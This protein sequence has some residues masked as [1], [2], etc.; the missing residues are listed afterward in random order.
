MRR[1]L[2]LTAALVLIIGAAVMFGRSARVESRKVN[3]LLISIDTVRADHLGCYGYGRDTSPNIDSLARRGVLFTNATSQAP[4]TLVSHMSAFTSLL[5]SY[6]KVESIN[7]ILSPAIPVLAE[8]LRDAGWETAGI[9]NDGQM[10]AHWGFARG[11]NLWEERKAMTPDGRIALEGRAGPIT[12]RTITWVEEHVTGKDSAKPFF[13]FIHYFDAHDPYAPPPP[14]D[15]MFAP[16]DD[17]PLDGEQTGELLQVLR[18]TKE[19]LSD[20]RLLPKLISLYDGEIRYNDYHIG[21]LF[22]TLDRLGLR[23]DTLVI[24]F[25]DHG[26]EFREHGSFLHGGTLYEE[27]IRVPLIISL[28]GRV[29]EGVRAAQPARLIDI[30]PTIFRLCGVET[31]PHAQGQSLMPLEFNVA[32]FA[33]I[34]M[35]SETKALLEGTVLKTIRLCDLKYI[36]SPIGLCEELYDLRN[37]PREERNLAGETR[38][39]EEFRRE[40]ERWFNRTEHYWLIRFV[41][42]ESYTTFSATLELDKGVFGVIVPVGFILSPAQ[43]GTLDSLSFSESLDRLRVSVSSRGEIK[44]I[45]VESRPN[46]AAITVDLRIDEFFAEPESVYI[47]K[48]RRNPEDM[49]FSIASNLGDASSPFVLGGNEPLLAGPVIIIEEYV[50]PEKTA[51]PLQV[52]TERRL[53]ETILRQLRQLGYMQ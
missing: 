47:G 31:P 9:V 52:D 43:A 39:L 48:S 2:V 16:A 40:M 3:V 50:S 20:S 14:Y 27:V 8:L 18:W 19:P 37:D 26:E 44:A 6:H 10:Q 46:G 35:K 25:S 7:D 23:D 34:P 36:Y 15:T 1:R 5:P 33:D 53:D 29:P 49:P 22:D 28:P 51:D 41:P 17:I 12:D 32:R 30:L 21:R 45:Y 24:V 38:A 11:F 13:L 4:W 42:G